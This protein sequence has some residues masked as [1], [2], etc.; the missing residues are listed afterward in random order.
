MPSEIEWTGESANPVVGCSR[1][2]PGCLNCYAEKMAHR[3]S[4]MP[5]SSQ[6]VG[7]VK[8]R[9][10]TGVVHYVPKQLEKFERKKPEWH[11]LGLV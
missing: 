10:W 1:K 7:T 3:L 2:S 9:K 4:A 11:S 8:N 6:Y 5:A